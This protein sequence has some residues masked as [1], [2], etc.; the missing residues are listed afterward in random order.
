MTDPW[1]RSSRARVQRPPTEAVEIELDGPHG[2]ERTPPA[3]ND[4]EPN[5][6]VAAGASAVVGLVLVQ[7]F[8]LGAEPEITLPDPSDVVPG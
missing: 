5:W 7:R 6:R 4:D 2:G 3:D 8:D 1:A